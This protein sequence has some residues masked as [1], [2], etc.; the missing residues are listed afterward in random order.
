MAYSPRIMTYDT[1]LI[2][3]TSTGSANYYTAH[4]L[5]G[6]IIK[7]GVLTRASGTLTLTE[8]GTGDS[9]LSNAV[10]SGTAYT[11]FY[12]RAL[13]CTNAGVALN[14]ASGNVWG[15]AVVSNYIRVQHTAGSAAAG[16][17]FTNVKIYY[18]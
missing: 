10:A 11:I 2:T 13:T 17:S 18:I 8:S 12:P 1:G 3:T 16:I 14:Y 15:E 6:K 4:A 7:V 5:V 9:I